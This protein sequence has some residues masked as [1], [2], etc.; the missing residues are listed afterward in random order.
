MTPI[1][2]LKNTL[3]NFRGHNQQPDEFVALSTLSSY[4]RHS[5]E[6]CLCLFDLQRDRKIKDGVKYINRCNV[7]DEPIYIE[8][9]EDGKLTATKVCSAPNGLPPF[10]VVLDCPSGKMVF[11]NDF[12]DIVTI[13]NKYNVNAIIGTINTIKAYEK[14]DMLHILVGNSCPAVF[15]RGDTEL[16][17]T[18]E[19]DEE[20]DDRKSPGEGYEEITSI[21]TDLW[22][23]SA[24]DYDLFKA[25]CEKTGI[26]EE[27][28]GVEMVLD[29]KPGKWAFSFDPMKGCEFT[30]CF[31]RHQ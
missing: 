4:W 11:G 26:K 27:N 5:L 25:Q 1:E 18:R 23:V 15:Q 9:V 2:E 14:A 21:T 13:D 30:T 6:M 8:Q 19:F 16:C 28:L 31:G 12:R 7:C 17:I 3:V 20:T 24:M 29:V 10:D 22:W